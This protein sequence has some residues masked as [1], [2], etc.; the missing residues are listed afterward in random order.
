MNKLIRLFYTVINPLRMA[1]WFIFRPKTKGVKCL[2]EHKGR[3]LF[4]KLSYAHKSWTFPGGGVHRGET[5]EAAAYRELAEETGLKNIVLIKFGE[6]F[7][8]RQ[9]KRDTVECYFGKTADPAFKVDG[10]EIT[11]AGWYLR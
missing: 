9:Y 8:T 3:F 4:V 5:F 1:Y 11:E 10:F 6:Y 7:N 2:I